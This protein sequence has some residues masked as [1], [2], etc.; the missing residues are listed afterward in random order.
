M[1]P[2]TC[3]CMH[4]C[5]CMYLLCMYACVRVT[6]VCMRACGSLMCGCNTSIHCRCAYHTHRTMLT[7]REAALVLAAMVA[8]ATSAAVAMGYRR[9]RGTITPAPLP[10]FAEALA[11]DE[12]LHAVRLRE[13]EDMAWRAFTA[14][15]L[16]TSTKEST[17]STCVYIP[18]RKAMERS[19][20]TLSSDVG[21]SKTA[22]AMSR[23]SSASGT[24]P[25]CRPD[26]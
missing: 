6:D 23:L 10:P 13:W 3:V 8:G 16:D 12:T 2:C 24:W 4:V 26:A 9:R 15:F 17:R 7:A 14:S 18:C 5:V 11:A 22:S 20:P 19:K 1:W 21:M 25:I